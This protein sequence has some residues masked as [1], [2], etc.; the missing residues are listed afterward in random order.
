MD[1]PLC[2]HPIAQTQSGTFLRAASPC[3]WL[4][5]ARSTISP[6][7]FPIP[8]WQVLAFY[9]LFHHTLAGEIGISQVYV[10]S[11]SRRT[12]V[13]DPGRERITCQCVIP[14]AAFHYMK[15]VGLY[16]V[17]YYGALSL[18]LRCGLSCPSSKLHII[19]YLLMC[20]IRFYAD[21]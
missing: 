3:T 10:S 21:G 8:I 12:T 15:S 13:S 2:V 9:S 5:H 14:L 19:R 1:S 17:E 16:N 20:R 18:H 6:S 7:D 4:S 11:I